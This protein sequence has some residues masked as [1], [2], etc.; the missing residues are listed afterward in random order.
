MDNQKRRQ[1]KQT[2]RKFI[3][4]LMEFYRNVFQTKASSEGLN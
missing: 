1:I 2:V 3:D 4:T